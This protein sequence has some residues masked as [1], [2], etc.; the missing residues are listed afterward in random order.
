MVRRNRPEVWVCGWGTAT[1]GNN[2]GGGSGSVAGNIRS[3]KRLFRC[4]H[5]L[6]AWLA[7]LAARSSLGDVLVP[8]SFGGGRG[9]ER[10]GRSRAYHAY[11]L[12]GTSAQHR[13]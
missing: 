4:S 9:E 3:R 5:T 6:L 1:A 11:Q 12:V 7:W 10:S 13:R 8:Y 2:G